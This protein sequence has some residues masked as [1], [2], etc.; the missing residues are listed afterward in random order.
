MTGQAAMGERAR[1]KAGGIGYDR[2][3]FAWLLNAP[4]LIAIFL[5]AGYPIIH[6]AWLSLHKYNLKRPNVFQFIG[7]DNYAAILDSA[8][9]WSSLWITMQF[10]LLVVTTVTV[11]GVCIALL[12]NMPF[13]GRGLLRT[14]ILLPW[15]IPPVVNG[16]MWQWIYDS[17]IGA[18]NGLLVSLG[19]L[20]EYKGWLSSPTSALL[21][22]A[23]ADVWNVLPL[24]VILLLAAL[25]KIPAELYESA[26]MDGAGP[27]Q[28]FR[29]VTFPWLAQT[30]LVVLILQTLSAIRVF[31]VIYVLTAGGPG[32]ATTTLTWKT[33]LTTFENL[34]FGMGN[35]YAY[36]VSLITFGFALIYF[37]VLYRRG[38]FET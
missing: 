31:D 25:Q 20:T 7:L 23:F 1:A 17:K 33:Y 9:F 14:L 37:R 10:T 5:L 3:L 16:L 18:L 8:E 21:A 36:T 2:P 13:R 4:A 26:R 15:A 11:L 38:D 6:S 34:D 19:I 27:F 28:L 30:L 29:H 32:T 24:A 12:L 35:A 22:L